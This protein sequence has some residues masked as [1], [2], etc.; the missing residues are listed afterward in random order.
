MPVMSYS[1]YVVPSN[2]RCMDRLRYL[3]PHQT[4]WSGPI[5]R[6]VKHAVLGLIEQRML[7]IEAADAML[8]E[9]AV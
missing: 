8:R 9:P 6:G 5:L 2:L 1:L 4:N 3:P 7:A